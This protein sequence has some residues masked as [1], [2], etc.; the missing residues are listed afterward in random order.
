MATQDFNPNAAGHQL[1]TIGPL[2]PGVDTPIK[3]TAKHYDEDTGE[4]TGP[5]DWTGWTLPEFFIGSDNPRERGFISLVNI[6]CTF[7]NDLTNG[8]IQLMVTR[9]HM[10]LV[11]PAGINQGYGGFSAVSPEG[12]RQAVTPAMWFMDEWSS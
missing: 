10:E 6:P 7:S 8:E 1:I 2:R 4:P 12:V 9:A 11:T 5:F 3:V